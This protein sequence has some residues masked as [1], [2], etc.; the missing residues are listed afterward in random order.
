MYLRTKSCFEIA[1]KN[2]LA[3]NY[4]ALLGHTLQF[5]TFGLKNKPTLSSKEKK[6]LWRTYSAVIEGKWINMLSLP[7]KFN[8]KEVEKQQV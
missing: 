8:N 5:K 4:E 3:F 7:Q 2:E 1:F 6:W